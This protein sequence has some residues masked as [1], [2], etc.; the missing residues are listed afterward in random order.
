[1]EMLETI[2]QRKLGIDSVLI[3]RNG[4]IVEEKYYPPYTENTAM[5]FI[6]VLRVLFLP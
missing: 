3:V 6:L 2:D 1:M 5:N 4:T